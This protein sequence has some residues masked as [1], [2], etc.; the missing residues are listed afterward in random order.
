[1]AS[2]HFCIGMKIVWVE[3]TGPEFILNVTT[4]Q[5]TNEH[6]ENYAT[7]KFSIKNV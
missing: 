4:W 6:I 3:G 2:H 1:M 5:M 7:I